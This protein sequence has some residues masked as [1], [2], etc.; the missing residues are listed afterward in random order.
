[1]PLR[2]SRCLIPA[3]AFFEWRLEGTRKVKYR[4]A[5][6]IEDLFCFAGVYDTWRDPRDPHGHGLRSFTLN[7]TTPNDLVATC[8]H[9]MPVI[10][11]SHDEDVWLDSSMRDA[12]SITSLLRPFPS[13]MMCV[14][15]T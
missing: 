11:H 5:R 9:R 3:S 2:R 14:Q 4:F 13:D 10:L 15:A 7:T 12:I 1:G 6:P 8:P